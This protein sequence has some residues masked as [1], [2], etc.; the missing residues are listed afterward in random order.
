MKKFIA[1]IFLAIL[2]FSCSTSTESETMSSLEGNWD[3]GEWG[4]SNIKTSEYTLT[5][6]GTKYNGEYSNK[7]FTGNNSFFSN[8]S[9]YELTLDITLV[10]DNKISGSLQTKISPIDGY[11]TTEKEYFTGERK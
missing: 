6:L 5:F 3:L 2:L 4:Y 11:M 10:S 1:I 9:H 8:G 7:S